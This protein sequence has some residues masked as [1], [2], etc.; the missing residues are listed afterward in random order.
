MCNLNLESDSQT[1]DTKQVGSSRPK[2][3]EKPKDQTN[4]KPAIKESLPAEP[5]ATATGNGD[6]VG[7]QI[8]EQ[9]IQS[10][11][12]FIT[13]RYFYVIPINFLQEIKFAI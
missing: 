2:K 7:A 4:T 11:T 5:M 9:G 12:N 13:L 10:F 8:R 3:Q 6:A 1:S